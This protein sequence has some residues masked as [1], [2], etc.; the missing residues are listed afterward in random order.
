M[1]KLKYALSLAF[2]VINSHLK[3]MSLVNKR[4]NYERVK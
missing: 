4:I 1:I 3:E 2:L